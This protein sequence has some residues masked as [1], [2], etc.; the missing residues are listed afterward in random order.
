MLG[1][2]GALSLPSCHM[3][4]AHCLDRPQRFHGSTRKSHHLGFRPHPQLWAIE[5]WNLR[6]VATPG[7][8]HLPGDYTSA[9]PDVFDVGYKVESGAYTGG[10]MIITVDPDRRWN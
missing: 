2:A 4:C 1:A 9:G 5:L 3:P 6:Q 10:V 8:L 7:F